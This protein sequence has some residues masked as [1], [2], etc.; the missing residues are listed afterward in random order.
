LHYKQKIKTMNT[1]LWIAQGILAIFIIAGF[2]KLTQPKEKLA[3]RM[4]WVNSF[5]S[6][7][8][9]LIGLSQILGGI[10]V[11]LPWLTGIAPVLTPIA[12]S[13]LALVMV[14][15]AIYHI[16]HKEYSSIGINFFF[17]AI[18]VFVAYGRF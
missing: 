13:G 3:E 14:F 17:G 15:A 18:A 4:P 11:I 12:A 7:Q 5:S 10:G 2:I 6:I 9:K 8:V 1:A 16:M